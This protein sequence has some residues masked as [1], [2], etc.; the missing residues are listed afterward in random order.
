M[1]SGDGVIMSN[2][3]TSGITSERNVTF[4]PLHTSHGAEYTCQANISIILSSIS[5][6]KTGNKSIE[7]MIQSEWLHHVLHAC[8]MLY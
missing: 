5:L 8:R 2:I 1:G 4:N 3:T 6:V 7:V